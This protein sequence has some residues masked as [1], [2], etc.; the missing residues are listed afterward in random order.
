[1]GTEG[2]FQLGL[3]EVTG[4]FVDPRPGQRLLES[5]Q[6]TQI[7]ARVP[8]TEQ[9][10]DG[11]QRITPIE[12]VANDAQPGQMTFSVIP[13]AADLHRWRQQAP[14]LIGA[15]VAGGD[16]GPTGELVDGQ[17][18]HVRTL[19]SIPSRTVP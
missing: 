15:D 19:A 14:L 4:R 7:A 9:L 2:R 18:V 10:A 5:E 17:P 11:C 16:A 12:Q 13:G 6:L 3:G 8:S 1:M